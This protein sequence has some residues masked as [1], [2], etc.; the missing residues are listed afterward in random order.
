MNGRSSRLVSTT[1]TALLYAQGLFG[2]TAVAAV[3]L[4]DR[5]LDAPAAHTTLVA[6]ASSDAQLR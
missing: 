1:L 6:A 5:V 4:K 3:V 2:L